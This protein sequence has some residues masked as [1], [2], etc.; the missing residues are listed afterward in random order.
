ME[1][2]PSEVGAVGAIKEWA[3]LIALAVRWGAVVVGGMSLLLYAGEIGHFPS[4]IG[5]GEGLAFYL[6]CTAFFLLYFLYWTA[7]TAIGAVL[8]RA[9]FEWLLRLDR[10]RGKSNPNH[11]HLPHLIPL[12]R[13]TSLEVITTAVIGLWFLVKL[14]LD[15]EP[16]WYWLLLIALVQGLMVGLWLIIKRQQEFSRVSFG[17]IKADEP[18]RQR[19]RLFALRASAVLILVLPFLLM[20]D[21]KG[22]VD[23]T[24]GWS[25]LRKENAV[26]HIKAPWT[27]LLDTVY[28]PGQK[29]FRGSDYK[30]Y[31]G[32]TVLLRSLGDSVVIAV[33]TELPDPAK[34]KLGTVVEVRS[35]QIKR[36][37]IP[38]TDIWVE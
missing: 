5:L 21:R 12:G 25:Q 4:G 36:I 13:M 29:S 32:V 7:V 6:I 22:F 2:D 15:G 16:R 33:P 24:F 20:P 28:V 27:A 10:K 1:T 17:G 26:V 11:Q 3:S 19:E 18:K 30:R 8:M 35:D 37:S 14:C 23:T 38:A 31:T 9:P 34:S